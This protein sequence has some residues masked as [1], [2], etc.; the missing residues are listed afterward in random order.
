MSTGVDQSVKEILRLIEEDENSAAKEAEVYYP[1][2]PE[3]I[4]HVVKLR[5]LHQLLA[6]RYDQLTGE[7][8]RNFPSLVEMQYSGISDS[9]SHQTS[10]LQ[11]P[12][13]KLSMNKSEQTVG[14][15]SF[16]SSG[17]GSPNISL[18]ESSE[19]SLSLSSDSD[20]ES[21]YSTINKNLVSPV[22]VDSKGLHYKYVE[23]ETEL[24][25][26]EVKV[27]GIKQENVDDTTKVREFGDYETLLKRITECAD[28]L[29]ISNK[30]LQFSENEN[31][32]LKVELKMNESV[33]ELVDHLKVQLDSSQHG[34]KMRD[35]SLEMEKRKVQEL[36]NQVAELETQI[37]DSEFN[38]GSLR[39]EL[40]M[41]REKL[42][43]LEEELAKLKHERWNEISEGTRHFQTQLDFTHKEIALLEAKLDSEKNQVSELQEK[44]L[45]YIAGISQRDNIISELNAAMCDTH[46][47]FSL[48]K[49]QLQS[50]ISDLL[51]Q[52]IILTAGIRECEMQ[53]RALQNEINNIR[54]EKKEMK[55]LH[56]AQGISWQVDIERMKA[57]VNGKGEVVEAM[58]KDVDVLKLK[59]DMLMA[60]KD[61]VNA[62]VDTLNA[63]L[64]CRDDKIREMEN[65]LRQLHLEHV[66]LIAGSERAQ[67]HTNEVRSKVE[68][69]QKEV[70][71]QRAVISDSAEEKREAIRQLCFSLEHYRTGYQEL[72]QAYTGHKQRSVLAS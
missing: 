43:G 6:E 16:I 20:S 71:S 55:D 57:E 9:G 23:W 46:K 49:E 37:G 14:F 60:E 66:E 19:Y 36:Q 15:N 24:P 59:Y 45:G 28:D 25:G 33:I 26:I 41:T 52:E 68:E 29:R 72:R 1:K 56:D 63:E 17:G 11:T 58:N 4:A 61:E 7:V 30:K 2:K 67:K 13:Q 39:E 48:E 70:E 18:K 51:E 10:A 8:R 27:Q 31:A 53:A 44:I 64:C 50:D 21:F 69:L 54:V 62:E 3:L 5:S 34:I 12:D 42:R 32:R 35:S 40:K 22:S 47:K 38:V 65:H